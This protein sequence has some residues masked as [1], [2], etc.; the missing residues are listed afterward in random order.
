MTTVPA[1]SRCRVFELRQY[2]LRPGRRDDLV[3]LFER[4]L[5][6]PQ[7]AVGM[8]VLG[9]FRDLDDADR[10][11]WLRGF[12]DMKS[13]RSGLEA[14]YG[15]P[16][17]A[18]YGAEANATMLDSD[19]VLLLRP[20]DPPH[21]LPGGAARSAGSTARRPECVAVTVYLVRP[22]DDQ[23]VQWLTQ[24]AGP[25]LERVLGV[26]VSTLRTDAAD[27]NF[28][29]LPVRTGE[30]AFVWLAAFDDVQQHGR[31]MTRLQSDPDWT[32]T[33][34]PRL[35]AQLLGGQELRLAPTATSAFP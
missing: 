19:D 32:G 21:P 9:T 5:V 33:V 13:R 25:L 18:R 30:S 26:P 16:V 1:T 14:F 8:R 34:L 29:S 11:V 31:A 17:W 24:L 4:E 23:L 6:A 27:N 12:G 15:G 20:T 35:D 28:P 7:E 22:G 10:F 2:T 3:E